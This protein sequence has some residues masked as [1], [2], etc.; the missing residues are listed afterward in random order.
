MK[1]ARKRERERGK[2]KK[3][4]HVV[5][6]AGVRFTKLARESGHPTVGDGGG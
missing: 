2:E 6:A 1:S 5:K 4:K 3:G